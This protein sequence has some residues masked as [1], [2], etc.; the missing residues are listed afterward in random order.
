MKFISIT[1]LVICVFTSQAMAVAVVK[2]EVQGLATRTSVD[3]LFLASTNNAG[4]QL[5]SYS[6]RHLTI[7]FAATECTQPEFQDFTT[8]PCSDSETCRGNFP[9]PQAAVTVLR[10]ANNCHLTLY[11]DVNQGGDRTRLET[12]TTTECVTA[13][14]SNLWKSY[15]LY[16]I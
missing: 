1:A 13:T 2:P 11:Q 7:F 8:Y 10:T 12:D 3:L 6:R 9:A 16:C 5:S 14:T 4:M 15:G